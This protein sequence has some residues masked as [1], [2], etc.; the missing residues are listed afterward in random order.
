MSGRRTRRQRRR[1]PY[2]HREYGPRQAD[3]LVEI[4]AAL[5]REP[6]LVAAVSKDIEGVLPVDQ[7]MTAEQCL[8]AFVIKDMNEYDFATLEQKLADSRAYERFCGTDALGEGARTKAT[9]EAYLEKISSTTIE[10]LHAVLVKSK[11]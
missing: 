2:R 4:D 3:E 6:E 1:G 11:E 10:A 8:R 5:R 7:T 9:L